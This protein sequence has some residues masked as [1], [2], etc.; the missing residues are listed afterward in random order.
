MLLYPRTDKNP[1]DHPFGWLVGNP[2]SAKIEPLKPLTFGG[3]SAPSVAPRSRSTVTHSCAEEHGGTISLK[4]QQQ[5]PSALKCRG[6][7]SD[8][9]LRTLVGRKARGYSGEPSP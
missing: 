8:M 6:S 3:I 4:E 1:C 9:L 7:W 5:T 2:E